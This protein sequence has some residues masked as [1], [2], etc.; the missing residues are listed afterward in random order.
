MF[1]YEFSAWL[2]VVVQ[3]LLLYIIQVHRYYYI[4]TITK[5]ML[6]ICISQDFK[7]TMQQYKLAL[8][9]VLL[10]LQFEVCSLFRKTKIMWKHHHHHRLPWCW[11]G[12]KEGEQNIWF[13]LRVFLLLPFN[14]LVSSQFSSKQLLVESQVLNTKILLKFWKTKKNIKKFLRKVLPISP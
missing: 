1:V 2:V 6:Q 11:F 14:I 13:V 7:W 9:S 4:S 8:F 12:W 10:L 3:K 5:G